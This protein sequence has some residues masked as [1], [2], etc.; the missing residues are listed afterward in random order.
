LIRDVVALGVDAG[1][2]EQAPGCDGEA[3]DRAD[4]D[5]HLALLDQGW[6]P[7]SIESCSK[8]DRRRA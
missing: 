4:E 7:I 6:T 1:G 3:R 8:P 5:R 2:G